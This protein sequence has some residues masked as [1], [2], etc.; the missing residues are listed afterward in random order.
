MNEV[1]DPLA[2]CLMSC[3]FQ[4]NESQLTKCEHILFYSDSDQIFRV[5]I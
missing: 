2:D 1:S 4:S 5:S 3:A